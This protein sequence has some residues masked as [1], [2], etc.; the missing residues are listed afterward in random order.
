[1]RL[2]TEYSFGLFEDGRVDFQSFRPRT[3]FY[4]YE[5][6]FNQRH[7]FGTKVLMGINA[8][9]E[10][11]ATVEPIEVRTVGASIGGNRRLSTFTDVLISLS[12]ERIRRKSPD[13]GSERSTSRIITGTV[14]HDRRDFI[15]DPRVGSYRDLRLEVAGGVLGGDND[16]YTMSSSFQKYLGVGKGVVLALRLRLGFA[17]AFGDSKNRGV[18]IENR[19]FTGGGNSVRGYDENSLGP[20]SATGAV[21]GE[22]AV[23]G[24]RLLALTNAE[25]RF[26]LPLLSRFRLA[27]AFFVDGGNVWASLQSVEAKHFRVVVD[28][29]DILQEDYRYGIGVGIR[30][31]TPVG[32][33]RLDYG[34]PIKRDPGM[35][36]FGRFH[37]SLGQIF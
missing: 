36:Q 14:R 4:R 34:I 15:L 21:P 24:G 8:F 29:S 37:V 3:Q 6:E 28:E 30:Y 33:I 18:P 22:S 17:D 25:L 20:Q 31:N 5:G 32:P 23:L 27:G 7:V 9:L 2:R 12:H 1:L 16:F 26:P 19:F 35:D 13:I 11:D 10:K